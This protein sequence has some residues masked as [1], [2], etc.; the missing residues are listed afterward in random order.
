MKAAIYHAPRNI[1]LI[2]HRFKLT[3]FEKAIATSDNPAEKPIKIII[4]E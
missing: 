1:S 4:T 2:T 3:D